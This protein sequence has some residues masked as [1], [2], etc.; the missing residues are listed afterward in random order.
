VYVAVCRP[1]KRTISFLS[2]VLKATEVLQTFFL[3][4]DFIEGIEKG[5]IFA[6]SRLHCPGLSNRM[7][8]KNERSNKF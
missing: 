4:V 1:K 6:G 7:P 8:S 2:Q 3:T 5:G